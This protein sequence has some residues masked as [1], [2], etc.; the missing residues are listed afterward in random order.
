M[1]RVVGSVKSFTIAAECTP[2]WAWTRS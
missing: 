1:R 2:S